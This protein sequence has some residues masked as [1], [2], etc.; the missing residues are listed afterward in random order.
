MLA[1]SCHYVIIHVDDKHAF[2]VDCN[3]HGIVH[4]VENYRTAW[5]LYL[6]AKK[7]A[8]KVQLKL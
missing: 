4:L 7:C 1:V 2:S 8:P 6:T 5:L 3:P